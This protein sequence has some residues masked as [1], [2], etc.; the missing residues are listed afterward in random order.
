MTEVILFP[1]N[2]QVGKFYTVP[3]VQ[4][5]W[6]EYWPINSYLHE[7]AKIIKFPYKHWHIDW[8]FVHNTLYFEECISIWEPPSFVEVKKVLNLLDGELNDEIPFDK[9]YTT[10]N[11]EVHYK[12]V[13][14]KRNYG[15]A[16]FSTDNRKK[17]KGWPKDLARHFCKSKLKEV[18]GQ[19]ICPHKGIVI[20]R[21]CK[22]M[23]GNYVCPGHLL[24]FNPETLS[25]I[26]HT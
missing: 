12:K 21:N 25:V 1:E 3:H 18:D 4:N 22:D 9:R 13:K 23:D 16:M 17:L 10:F 15:A 26:Q 7:D 2:V 19:L 11:P 8:R 20:D 14:C 24:K 5:V 6:G